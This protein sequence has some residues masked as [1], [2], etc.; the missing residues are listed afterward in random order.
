MKSSY[1]N[2]NLSNYLSKLMK[3]INKEELALIL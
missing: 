1:V 3:K 2:D